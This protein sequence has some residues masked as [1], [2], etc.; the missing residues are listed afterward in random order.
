MQRIV[1]QMAGAMLVTRIGG[2]ACA[3]PVAHVVETMRPLPVEPLAT[4]G[5]RALALVDGLA[6][7]RGAPVPVV[8]ARKLLGVSGAAATRFV[9]VRAAQRRIALVVDAVL[10]VRRIDVDALPGLPPLLSGARDVVSALGALDA[11]L[12]V[13]LDSARVLPEDGW[14]ALERGGAP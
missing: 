13:V 1:R 11:E 5:D 10:E 3:L 14:R 4:P 6:M 7:I 2:L 12:L 8:D 9:V